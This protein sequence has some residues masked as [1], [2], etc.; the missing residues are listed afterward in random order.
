MLNESLITQIKAYLHHY[1][2][3]TTLAT[4]IKFQAS[5]ISDEGIFEKTRLG[6]IS[7]LFFRKMERRTLEL[8]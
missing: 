4:I 8:R 1:I 3:S 5:M 6:I 2:L 7:S